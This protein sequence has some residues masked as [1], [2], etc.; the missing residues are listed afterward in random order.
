[1]EMVCWI[2]LY[3]L[4]E[5]GIFVPEIIF[6]SHYR[7]IPSLLL[8]S[9]MLFSKLTKY[10]NVI[11]FVRA[12]SRRC[13][14]N[15]APSVSAH[16]AMSS[17]T[18]SRSCFNSSAP[19]ASSTWNKCQ[20]QSKAVQTSLILAHL[21]VSLHHF[22]QKLRVHF[23]I[24]LWN[25]DTMQLQQILSAPYGRMQRFVCI[26]N[27]WTPFG[28]QCLLLLASAKIENH[29]PTWIM[30]TKR[31][32]SWMISEHTCCWICPDAECLG[33][34]GIASAGHSNRCQIA[35]GVPVVESDPGTKRQ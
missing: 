28:R 4:S 27:Q 7:W 13:A 20:L 2:R 10:R 21:F 32:S 8:F 17:R 34:H 29:N 9:L 1:M 22:H 16:F 31:I 30:I 18:L 19:S 5:K 14:S 12:S 23:G 15:D 24:A 11:K 3:F 26:V 33:S 6:N 35:S 25:G